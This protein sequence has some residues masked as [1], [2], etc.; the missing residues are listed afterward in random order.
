MATTSK[1]YKAIGEDIWK[2][3]TEKTVSHGRTVPRC[4]HL[5]HT[6]ERGTVRTDIWRSR[7]TVDSGL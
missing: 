2:G 7:S 4:P 1:Q 3:R 5:H 6:T